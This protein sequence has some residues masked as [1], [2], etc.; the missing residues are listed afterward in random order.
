MVGFILI[1]ISCT[2]TP[3]ET[4]NSVGSGVPHP[5]WYQIGN[6]ECVSIRWTGWSTPVVQGVPEGAIIGWAQLWDENGS[7][8]LVQSCVEA[9]TAYD[10]TEGDCSQPENWWRPLCTIQKPMLD[11]PVYSNNWLTMSPDGG[12]GGYIV[13]G[14][15]GTIGPDGFPLPCDHVVSPDCIRPPNHFEKFVLNRA[16]SRI[17]DPFD[18]ADLTARNRCIQ[19]LDW[20]SKAKQWDMIRI[21]KN[22]GTHSGYFGAG[23]IHADCQMFTAAALNPANGDLELIRTY[24]HEATHSPGGHLGHST[25][26]H[27]SL[28]YFMEIEVAGPNSCVQ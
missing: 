28:P 18:I 27:A 4:S 25:T 26:T 23:T 21:S 14:G 2:M 24:L 10:W 22:A 7:N 16:E 19:I 12:G 17:R 11:A 20:S 8:T 3:T 13:G 5:R 15:G 6:L 9:Y 1:T